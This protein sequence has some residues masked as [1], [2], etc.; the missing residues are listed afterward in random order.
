MPSKLCSKLC[1]RAIACHYGQGEFKIG[2]LL[3]CLPDALISLVSLELL[4]TSASVL[5]SLCALKI[6]GACYTPSGASQIFS[7]TVACLFQKA[8]W[9][10]TFCKQSSGRS[11]KVYD[12]TIMLDRATEGVCRIERATLKS[13]R[14]SRSAYYVIMITKF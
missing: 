12:W 1:L 11:L 5:S 9:Q 8:S 10:G 14:P 13:Q 3:A 2:P 4:I 6:P 7:S